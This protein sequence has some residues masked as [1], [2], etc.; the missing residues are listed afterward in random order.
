MGAARNRLLPGPAHHTAAVP[1]RA[2]TGTLLVTSA[3]VIAAAALS[4]LYHGDHDVAAKE[5]TTIAAFVAGKSGTTHFA[6]ATDEQAGQHEQ[7]STDVVADVSAPVPAPTASAPAPVGAPQSVQQAA[8]APLTGED[9]VVLAAYQRHLDDLGLTEVHL[10]L[11]WAQVCGQ[12]D[13]G[14]NAVQ[15]CV[16]S[17]DP[18]VIHVKR[19]SAD[20]VATGA[21]RAVVMVEATDML[22]GRYDD[23]R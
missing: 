21:G 5:P 11:D 23:Q 13:A 10:K 20:L 15:G 2:G 6:T 14:L 18:T 19:V 22:A 12:Q 4:G 1:D 16:L 7:G 3:L 9:E 17:T 8:V